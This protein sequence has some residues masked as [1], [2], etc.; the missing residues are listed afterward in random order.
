MKAFLDEWV[1]GLAERGLV[2]GLFHVSTSH[3]GFVLGSPWTKVSHSGMDRFLF[4]ISKF[5][6]NSLGNYSSSRFHTL[7]FVMA[8]LEL[9]ILMFAANSLGCFVCVAFVPF[10]LYWY[11]YFSIH[12][13][14]LMFFGL[15]QG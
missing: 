9:A 8:A 10:R 11:L 7:C 13:C 5:G 15:C 3:F 1:S 14:S 2:F 12:S 4:S 6:L